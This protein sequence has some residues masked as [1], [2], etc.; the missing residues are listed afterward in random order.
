MLNG[1]ALQGKHKLMVLDNFKKIHVLFRK[2]N[3]SRVL[4]VKIC[5]V[6]EYDNN[7]PCPFNGNLYLK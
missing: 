3:N 6:I 2:K 1:I 5:T 4:T 7:R